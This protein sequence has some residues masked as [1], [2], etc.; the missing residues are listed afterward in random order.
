VPYRY[1]RGEHRHKHCWKN[2]HAGFALWQGRYQVGKCPKTI[3][4]VVAETLLNQAVAEP[5]PFF[6]PGQ[7]KDK[8]PRRL[9]AVYRGV[10]YEAVPTQPGSYHG[11]PWQARP[12]RSPLPPEVIDQLR[13]MARKQGCAD[14]FEEWLDQHG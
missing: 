7:V 11:Y 13:D 2:D 3:T 12:G 8:W 1:E 5:D 14:E 6:V 4:D 10:I 9:Y